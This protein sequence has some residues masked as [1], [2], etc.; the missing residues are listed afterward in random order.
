MNSRADYCP[1]CGAQ[2][3]PEEQHCPFCGR[4]LHASMVM[5]FLIGL[6]GTAVA[7]VAG[8]AVWWVMSAGPSGE[9]A[10][11]PAATVATAPPPQ[12]APAAP[13][14]PVAAPQPA[15]PP[16]PETREAAAPLPTVG[17]PPPAP[18]VD[19]AAR[20]SFAKLK[21]DNFAQS[22]LDIAVTATGE[23]AT[24]LTMKFSFEAKPATDLIIEGPLPR[25]CEQRGF[26]Q[27]VFQDPSGVAWVYDISTRQLTQR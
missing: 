18:A 1:G 26:R 11:P 14:A 8:G 23:D 12:P 7:L 15:A 17:N 19:A 9:V 27:L 3:Y 4:K 20:R 16:V 6:G 25:Q 24:V 5:P 21:Q 13:A 22:G 2:V 10:A